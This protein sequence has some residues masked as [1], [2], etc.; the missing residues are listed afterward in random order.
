MFKALGPSKHAIGHTGKAAKALGEEVKNR[1]IP[2]Y[3]GSF[4]RASLC[5]A[6]VSEDSLEREAICTSLRQMIRAGRHR[7]SNV[8]TRVKKSGMPNGLLT[9]RDA[10]VLETLRTR[11]GT[12]LA[13]NSIN[14]G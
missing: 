12:A 8:K 10:P 7:P 6:R 5:G 13:P 3:T 1:I 9:L 11:H 14:P 2:Q 4:D